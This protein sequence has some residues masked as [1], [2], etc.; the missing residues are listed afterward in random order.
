MVILVANCTEHRV[1][2][3]LKA[4]DLVLQVVEVG[5]GLVGL[6]GDEH[7]EVH[8]VLRDLVNIYV[9]I[10][11]CVIINSGIVTPAP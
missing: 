1:H 11:I 2:H 8:E 6:I 9:I 4:M 3:R 10:N 7:L 5:Q